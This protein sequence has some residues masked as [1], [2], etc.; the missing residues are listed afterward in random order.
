MIQLIAAL[1]PLMIGAVLIWSARVKLLSRRAASNAG[2]SA[3]VALIGQRRALPAYRVLGGIELTIGILLVLPP[4]LAV[5]GAAATALAVGFT[6]YLCYAHARTPD[7]SCGCMSARRTPVSW[8]SF[9][10]A[11]FLVLAGLIASLVTADWPHSFATHPMAGAGLL[12][13]EVATVVA[14]S[15]ELDDEWL[16]PLRRLRARLMHPLVSGTGVPLL[17]TVQQLQ[18]SNAYRRVAAMLT[19]DVREYWDDGQ[20]RFVCQ[21][22]RYQGRLATAVFAVPLPRYEPPAVRVAIVDEATGVTVLAL[23]ST[24][25]TSETP[26]RPVANPTYA[27]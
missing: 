14:L 3:L 24:M 7:A 27:V 4:A 19:S 17:S 26:D 10:R 25:D 2:R 15:P 23:D 5:E 22:A 16:L 18:Q 12:L 8:R 11:G 6:G 13:A 1:Q 20:W 9:V 21:S